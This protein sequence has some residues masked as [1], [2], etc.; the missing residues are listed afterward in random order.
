VTRDV[1]AE[2]TMWRDLQLSLR[3]RKWGFDCPA[4][5]I[6]LLFCEY[7]RAYPVAIIEY[8]SA[9][10]ERVDCRSNASLKAIR[11][12]CDRAGIYFFV[13]RYAV[14][15]GIWRFRA[16][17]ANEKARYFLNGLGINNRWVA[18]E[19]FV[20]LLYDLRGREVPEQLADFLRGTA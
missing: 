2:Q 12:M 11:T 8:K 7:D 4:V 5:D 17:S 15:N 13:V 19:E 20:L 10:A 18:E 14:S 1:K 3:H 9:T 16:I 6:D